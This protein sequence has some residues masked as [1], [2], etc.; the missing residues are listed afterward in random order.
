MVTIKQYAAKHNINSKAAR[1]KLD[2]LVEAGEMIRTQGPNR[3]LAYT[4]PKPLRWHDPFNRTK[5]LERGK[6]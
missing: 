2:R 1:K 6:R 4:K 3:L 5:H